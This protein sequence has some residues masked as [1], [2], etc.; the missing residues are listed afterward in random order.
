MKSWAK[1]KSSANPLEG[2]VPK[3]GRNVNRKDIV[4]ENL[5]S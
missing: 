3:M 5:M 4:G 2:E 1:K